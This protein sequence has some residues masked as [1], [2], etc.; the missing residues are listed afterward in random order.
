MDG[1]DQHVCFDSRSAR[2]WLAVTWP[3]LLDSGF[4][5]FLNAGSVN[6]SGWHDTYLLDN[7]WA[8]NR[9][10]MKTAAVYTVSFLCSV[11]RDLMPQVGTVDIEKSVKGA[12]EQ[13]V[14]SNELS[15][16]EDRNKVRQ[17]IPFSRNGLD[18]FDCVG[19]CT[20]E[21]VVQVSLEL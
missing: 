1:P 11:D 18:R 3:Q 17:Y 9:V 19:G 2:D 16:C 5:Q 21:E 12:N 8:V 7:G 14:P 10:I 13:S 4:G 6:P 20:T 15:F